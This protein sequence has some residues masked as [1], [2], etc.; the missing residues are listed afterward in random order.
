MGYHSLFGGP[1]GI[2]PTL[3]QDFY[4]Q[5]F[6]HSPCHEDACTSCAVAEL[7]LCAMLLSTHE[8]NIR[9]VRLQTH[10]HF[11]LWLMVDHLSQLVVFVSHTIDHVSLLVEC[12]WSQTGN[13]SGGRLSH[14]TQVKN[15][16]S[17]EKKKLFQMIKKKTVHHFT[18]KQISAS[19]LDHGSLCR[20]YEYIAIFNHSHNLAFVVLLHEYGC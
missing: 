18:G 16:K 4:R 11:E 1:H 5:L 9:T 8:I 12:I 13:G 3:N 2:L 7:W 6:L 14:W 19:K 10:Q 17:L 15:Y 20:V